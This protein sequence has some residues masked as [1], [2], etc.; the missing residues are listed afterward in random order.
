MPLTDPSRRLLLKSLLASGF[1]S[2]AITTSTLV[3]ADDSQMQRYVGGAV[4]ADESPVAVIFDQHGNILA[5]VPLSAR[6]HGAASHPQTRQACLFAR[7]PGLYMNTFDIHS[8][9]EQRSIEP[10]AGR[11]FYGHG[12]YSTNGKLLYATENNFE[13][14]QGVLGIYDTEQQ[15]KRITEIATGG[16]GPHDVIRIPDSPLLVIANGGI[17]T[18]PDSGRDK[19]N[20][21]AMQPSIAI[22]DARTGDIVGQHFLPDDLHQMSIRHLAYVDSH[23]WFASQYEGDQPFVDGLAGVISIDETLSSFKAGKSQAGLTL[24]DVPAELQIQAQHY[25]TSIAVVGDYVIYTAAKGSVAFTVNRSTKQLE[26]SLSIFDCSGV[27]PMAPNMAA[28]GATDDTSLGAMI[29]TGTG[30][31]MQAAHGSVTVLA[32]HSLHWD[33]H[34]YHLPTV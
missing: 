34:M 18:H 19:L 17:R 6:A 16:I 24:I 9:S 21:D 33:N 2:N 3:A 15:Y 31:I 4:L 28:H 30:S 5:S 12:A 29:T 20:I 1:A 23:V 32:Q 10:V 25:M 27:A 7:R 11:H 22:I 8:P 14:S 13:T 26:H